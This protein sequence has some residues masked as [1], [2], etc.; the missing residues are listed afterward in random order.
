VSA[1]PRV[2]VT[3]CGDEFSAGASELV[4]RDFPIAGKF[5]EVAKGGELLEAARCQGELMRRCLLFAAWNLLLS[6]HVDFFP[7]MV[8]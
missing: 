5:V 1:E 4:L 7:K 2:G 8:D 6:K 3:V